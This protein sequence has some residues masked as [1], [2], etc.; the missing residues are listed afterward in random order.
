M[1][2][3]LLPYEERYRV[4]DWEQWNDPWELIHGMPYCMSPAPAF[5]HQ[6]LCSQLIV[7][8]GIQLRHC[9]KCRAIIPIDWET[10]EE[11]VVQP[12]I[13]ILC[14]PFEGNRLRQAPA[15]LFEIL[16]PS[17]QKKDRGIKYQLYQEQ[18]VP[19]YIMA[20]P[21]TRSTEAYQLGSDGKY[22]PLESTP[23]LILHL[24]DCQVILDMEAI[25]KSLEA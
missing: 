20:D 9:P 15:C 12:D 25:W 17:T 1:G 6:L 22:Q 16:S 8:L 4:S 3:A 10:D 5:K 24:G 14:Q 21:E 11:T 2:E 7:E 13:L 18:G 19:Y 23:E